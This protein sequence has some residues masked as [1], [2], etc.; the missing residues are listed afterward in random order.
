MR[1]LLPVFV[2]FSSCMGV[3]TDDEQPIDS[4]LPLEQDAG[5]LD[6]GFVFDAGSTIDAG[7]TIDAGVIADAG[8]PDAGMTIDSGIPDAGSTDPCGG[9]KLCERFD[10]YSTTTLSNN[11]TLGT[12][13]V[14]AP[15]PGITATLDANR[16]RSGKAFKIHMDQG[17]SSG[18]QLRTTSGPLFSTGRQQLYGRMWLYLGADGS[19]VHWTL[20]GASGTVPPGSASAGHRATYLFSAFQN[21]AGQ[22]NV[23]G[24][25]YYD[26]QTHQD[27]WNSSS[28]LI[29]TN[30]WACV[31]FFIDGPAMRYRF[32]LDGAPVP[33]M[34]VDTTGQGCVAHPAMSPWTGP[35]FSEFYVGAMSFHAMT[36]PMDLWID[37]VAVDTV[38]L[39]CP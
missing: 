29:P 28:Q 39:S 11:S 17:S 32:S 13:R 33:S 4:D 23:F 36:G 37:D 16:S 22:K 38:P 34:N 8:R 18:A 31:A 26:D 24:D 9:A 15:G 7:A 1:R 6:A 19:S 14:S 35:V 27:C 21:G 3:V 12:W 10:G 20:F 2:A 25:V 5:T 30:R